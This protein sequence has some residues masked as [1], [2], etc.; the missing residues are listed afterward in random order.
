MFIQNL[1]VNINLFNSGEIQETLFLK[2]FDILKNGCDSVQGKCSL[3]ISHLIHNQYK[4]LRRKEIIEMVLQDLAYSKS[5]KHRRSYIQFCS[6]CLTVLPLSLFITHFLEPL[7]DMAKDPM[8]EVKVFFLKG[9]ITIRPYLEK[10]VDLLLRFNSYLN[11]L[12]LSEN[13][14]VSKEAEQTD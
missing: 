6:V 9:A 3:F 1:S 10:D 8:N 4:T 11:A 2:I 12:R 5:Y 7:L 13:K 14:Q